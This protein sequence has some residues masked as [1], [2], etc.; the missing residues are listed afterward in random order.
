MLYFAPIS[1]GYLNSYARGRYSFP[2]APLMIRNSVQSASFLA[3]SHK[4]PFSSIRFS[5][6]SSSKLSMAALNSVETM[7]GWLND[8]IFSGDM[9][10]YIRRYG[11]LLLCDEFIIYLEDQI[12][13]TED[14]D[15]KTTFT[16][17]LNLIQK[18][19]SATDG[20]GGDSGLVF[21]HRFNDI[22]F[23]APSQRKAFIE[24]NLAAI[25]PGFIDYIRDN[26][27]TTQDR[28]SKVV[29]ASILKL[30]GEVKNNDF[31]GDATA[32]LHEFKVDGALEDVSQESKDGGSGSGKMNKDGAV[33]ARNEHILAS[34]TFT[35]NDLMEDILN[36]LH[37]IDDSFVAF[38]EDKI[39]DS[40][41]IDERVGL[42]SLR[43]TVV[44][45]L[46]RVKDVE[47][48]D[49]TSH[50]SDA[51]SLLNIKN[52]MDDIQLGQ[53][54]IP[55]YNKGN[56]DSVK[57]TS[58]TV[59]PFEVQK[60]K[61]DSFQTIISRF[62]NLSD[63]DLTAAVYDNYHL[64]DYEF[65]S[66]LSAKIDMYHE[67]GDEH[68]VVMYSNI[69]A[70]IS[71]A[72]ANVMGK[73]QEKLQR[74]ISKGNLK[75]MES[76]IVAMSNKG[77]IDEAL[78]LLLE[79]NLQQARSAGPQGEPAVGIMTTLI[80]RIN[81]EKDRS[82]PIENRLLRALLR[83]SSSEERK[84]LLY[85]AF[86]PSKTMTEDAQ[87]V[88][89]D[90]ELQPPIFIRTVR[91]FIRS[92]GNVESFD[93]MGRAQIIV[94]EAQIVATELYGEGMSPRQQQDYMFNKKSVSIW[95]LGNFEEQAAMSGEEIPWGNDAY[96][97]KNPE[98]V[99]GDRIKQIGGEDDG[100]WV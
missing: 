86:K 21:E 6:R 64:C 62:L 98:D 7:Q 40:K 27:K 59:A 54:A 22:L 1:D 4:L 60:I 72:M 78:V 90:P 2:T 73:A 81:R 33:G 36:N 3:R 96:N 43:D 19:V 57:V 69:Q 71:K 16:M 89:G 53:S 50:L 63:A 11:S 92:F 55:S 41:D 94:D 77:E 84:G 56:K 87:F 23:T 61:D 5:H 37:E 10:G 8:M 97:D 93:I 85:D 67:N 14:E 80:A 68:E 99:L 13:T 91:Q 35:S 38:L 95:D 58:K 30:I 12:G 34:L 83:V 70:E 100:K 46:E 52:R 45:V 32:L 79:A 28:S 76:E 44:S 49:E 15:E 75:A 88:E 26:I 51:D 17:A 66:M 24:A 42:T 29:I 25:T 20:V 39:S 48:S 9:E 31:L 82:L 74:I 47:Q 65:I 18:A